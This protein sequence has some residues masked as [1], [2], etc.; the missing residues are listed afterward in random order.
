VSKTIIPLGDRIL[1]RRRKVGER[2]GKSGLIIAPDEVK[3][4]RT[5]IADV[6]YVPDLTFTDKQLIE[7]AESIASSLA[8]KCRSGDSDALIALLRFNEF[9]KIKS[10]KAGDVVMIGKY[11]GTDFCTSDSTET[12]TIVFASDVIGLVKSE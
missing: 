4:A 6:V 1:C 2:L 3:D 9:A 10:I 5:D 8:E 7:N 11:V 12:I